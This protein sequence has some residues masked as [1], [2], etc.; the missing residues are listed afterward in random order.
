VHE[1]VEGDA[2]TGQLPSGHILEEFVNLRSFVGGVGTLDDFEELGKFNH[3]RMVIVYG[4][5]HF[6]DLLTRF[7][8]TQTDQGVLKFF[9]ANG[10]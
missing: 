10:S 4:I 9:N 7:S 6:L 5:N 3:P 8:K 2:L 1:H